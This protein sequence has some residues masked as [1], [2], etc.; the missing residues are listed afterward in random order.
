MSKTINLGRVTA[1]ADAVA[2]GY[3]GTRE[4]FANDL[5]NA[6]NYAAEAGD[7]AETATEAAT[8]ASTAAE[9]AT[10]KA[11]EASADAEQAHADAQAILGAKET[12]VAAASTASSK[13]GEAANSAQ[14]AAASETA[15]A[16]S[17]TTASNA[18]TSATASKN[19]AATSETN[20]AN[21]ANAAAQTLTNVNQAG[22]T[23][24][25]AI[26]AKGTEVLNSIP[27]D[28]TE[29]SNDVD[30]LKSDLDDITSVITSEN[31][32]DQANATITSGKYL[33]YTNGNEGT[34][35]DYC[36]VNDY[37]PVDAETDYFIS[38]W[39][40]T[41][42][43]L[44]GAYGGFTL[45]YD[46]NKAFISGLSAVATFTTPQ[47]CAF[48]RLSFSLA[49]WSD[50]YYMVAKGNLAPSAYEPYFKK[51]VL[52]LPFAVVDINGNGDYTSIQDAIDNA[53]EDATIFITPG[54]YVESVSTWETIN[55]SI[56]GKRVHLIGADK[57][58]TILKN[59]SQNYSTPPLEF[60]NG[61]IRN[62]TIYAE[63]GDTQ[64]EQNSCYAMHMET[65][66]LYGK[67][68]YFENCV[69]KSNVNYPIG[70]GLRGG[71]SNLTFKNC[72][73]IGNGT[74]AGC[75]WFHDADASAYRGACYVTYD[76]CNL[77]CDGNS[78]P[79]RINAMHDD[80]L[81]YLTFKRNIVWAK[82][83]E[84][85][86][87]YNTWNTGGVSGDGWRGLLKMYLTY[88]SV[89]NSESAM[90]YR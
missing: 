4:Q 22:A 83:N 52:K 17:A 44:S 7:A 56:F 8:T 11:E 30:D 57:T 76:G 81:T 21:S 48:I 45:F 10:T 49:G 18:A 27:A 20:A 87:I 32:F 3:T 85:A 63:G 35:E 23:Q 69:F 74:G 46:A 79:I 31:V 86:N 2:A 28:Y 24:V 33:N 82:T 53:V 71:G 89:L 55:G 42:L 62:M 67:D 6:A 9:T 26:Q 47:N 40:K 14:Q 58:T 5:A 25:A 68:A 41:T 1:Y 61:S 15:A 54:V 51:S 80:N 50:N 84:T 16:G 64:T 39:R 90:N 77:I 88:D 75:I 65:H 29:L 73:F 43:E 60:S 19:A 37:I 36:Y 34:N 59:T 78:Y 38:A 70:V 12:A 72:D 66:S 13:A